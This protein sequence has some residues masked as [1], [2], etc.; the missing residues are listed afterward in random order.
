MFRID[1]ASSTTSQPS[2]GTAGT[3][4]YFTDGNPGAAIPATIVT[5]D[6]LNIVQNEIAFVVTQSGD[7]LDKADDTQLYQA[8]VNIVTDNLPDVVI[9]PNVRPV[10]NYAINGSFD[11]AQ[12]FPNTTGKTSISSASGAKTY[13][14][15][16]WALQMSN[17]GTWTYK[18]T[19]DAP[20]T[21]SSQKCLEVVCTTAD[22]TVAASDYARIIQTIE[23]YDYRSMHGQSFILSFWVK[24]AITGTFGVC[25]Q[26]SAADR[27]YVGTYV[28]NATNTWEKKILAVTA[29]PTGTWNFDNLAGCNL[30]FTLAAG[31]TFQGT[32]GSWQSS[33]VFATSAQA[34]L[35]ATTN[36][37]FRLADVMIERGTVETKFEYLP[38][39]MQMG[40]CERFFEKSY[41]YETAIGAVTDAGCATWEENTI[42]E[43]A[44]L[45][46]LVGFRGEKRS[47]PTIT[48][49][50]PSTGASGNASVS[51]PDTV[52]RADMAITGVV[53]ANKRNLGTFTV[54]GT[55]GAAR[56]FAHWTADSEYNS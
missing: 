18:Q 56:L 16:R 10:K 19:V 3:L 36:N 27:S 49:Y 51:D 30:I 52:A 39:Q 45:I 37:Y 25:F 11:I 42:A 50:S 35:A 53:D 7:T 48:Y 22:T 17:H 14:I 8:I 38:I 32:A 43:K 13:V 15:D 46:S 2:R 12:R 28:I 34:N 9:T 1:N 5:Q 24:A 31:T 44:H 4:G 40:Q 33:N 20:S 41:N 26:N 55:G 54:S 6:W 29:V 21:S 47:T 23:G